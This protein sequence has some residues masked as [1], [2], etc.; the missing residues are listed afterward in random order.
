[1][2]EIVGKAL[3]GRE[4]A[5]QAAVEAASGAVADVARLTEDCASKTT[6]LEVQ[7]AAKCEEVL[8]KAAQKKEDIAV[9]GKRTSEHSAAQ[10][11]YGKRQDELVDAAKTKAL[12]EKVAAEDSRP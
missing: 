8:A 11:A 1:M 6:E 10:V 12:F 4:V 5:L 2:I 7:L 3:D 9:V